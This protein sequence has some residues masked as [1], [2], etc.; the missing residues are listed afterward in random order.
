MQ[1]RSG[2]GLSVAK[3]AS[4]ARVSGGHPGMC[5]SMYDVCSILGGMVVTSTWRTSGVGTGAG[6]EVSG[7]EGPREDRVLFA[8]GLS[9]LN[10]ASRGRGRAKLFGF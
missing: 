3:E 10:A 1:W 4:A 6:F 8:A 2:G 9:P 7:I 5:A